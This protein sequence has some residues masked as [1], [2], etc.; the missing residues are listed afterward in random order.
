MTFD[1]R[2]LTF[3]NPLPADAVDRCLR[4]MARP[5]DPDHVATVIDVGCG[6][7]EALAQLRELR[8]AAGA[9]D[10][11]VVGIDPDRGSIALAEKRHAQIQA[12]E[13]RALASPRWHAAP[14]PGFL[15]ETATWDGA[16]C[17]GSRHA[18]GAD[19]SAI[20][21]MV[22]KLVQRLRPSGSLFLADG[23]WRRP[24]DPEYLE[25]T[26][27]AESELVPLAT[28]EHRV[29]LRGLK[30]V[31]REIVS[32]EQFAAY[33]RPFWELGGEHWTNWRAAFER[34]GHDTMG[35]AGWVLE[36]A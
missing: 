10:C 24:P 1:P 8:L 12:P 6:N 9:A 32:P 3:R 34:W 30:I 23:Y 18:F 22:V 35:F 17:L 25:A 16:L 31:H 4:A 28:W 13:D 5:W 26:G 19:A 29:E 14:W 20:A 7:G 27:L 2:T 36:H 11:E 33:E 21:R 15:C